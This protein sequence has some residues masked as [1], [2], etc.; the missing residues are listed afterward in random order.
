MKSPIVKEGYSI[1]IAGTLILAVTGYACALLTPF[2]WLPFIL[3]WIWTISFFRNPNRNIERFSNIIYSPADGKIT[4]ITELD[5]HDTLNCP[6]IRIRIF[7]SIFN[8]HINRSPCETVVNSIKFKRG[9]FIN[10]MK[11]ESAEENESNTLLMATNKPICGPVIV[12]QISGLIART[13]VCN[14]KEGDSLKPGQPFGM[15]KF[16][17]GTEIIIPKQ[18]NL[19]IQ[20]KTGDKVKAGLTQLAIIDV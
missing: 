3:I 6:C 15:I 20:A 11:P 16:G 14:V 5:N 8:V 9:K 13:I 2:A 4:E 1:I 18:A 19:N 12:R 17:S 7:L 10:A